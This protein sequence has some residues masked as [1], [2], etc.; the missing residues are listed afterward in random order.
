MPRLIGTTPDP[1]PRVKTITVELER[2]LALALLIICNKVGGPPE[3]MRGL[4]SNGQGDE[5]SLGLIL[6]KALGREGA[7]ATER[8]EENL[9]AELEISGDPMGSMFFRP[10]KDDEET[11]CLLG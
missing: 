1:Q 5:L 8:L 7:W 6:R 11:G 4:F 10:I 9:G 2:E 3:G